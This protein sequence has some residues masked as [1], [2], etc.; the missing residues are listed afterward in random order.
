M[1][2]K[3]LSLTDVLV[4]SWCVERAPGPLLPLHQLLPGATATASSLVQTVLS[5]INVMEC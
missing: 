3:T 4:T 2:F 5:T 1:S